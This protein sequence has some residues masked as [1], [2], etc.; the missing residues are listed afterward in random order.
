M[1]P[2]RFHTGKRRD[3]FTT[4]THAVGFNGI[5]ATLWGVGMR[6]TNDR[7]SVGGI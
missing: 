3:G 6:M 7:S 2:S 5:V 1:H 4:M